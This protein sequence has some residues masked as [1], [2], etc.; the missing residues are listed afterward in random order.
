MVYKV[1]RKPAF[2]NLVFW[3]DSIKEMNEECIIGVVHDYIDLERDDYL[4]FSDDRK[5]SEK[6]NALFREISY[7]W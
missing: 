6:I 4:E 2:D 7:L 1:D 5:L 3:A